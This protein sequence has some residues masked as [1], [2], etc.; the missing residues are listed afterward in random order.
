MLPLARNIK[1]Y[2]SCKEIVI[3]VVAII[4]S[5]SAAVGVYLNLRSD[6]IINDNGKQIVVKTMK[7]TV[8]E[9]LAQNG[10]KV[11]CYDFISV[12]LESKLHK[13]KDNKIEIIRAVPINVF[14]DGKQNTL[15]TARSTVKEALVYSQYKLGADDRI[16]GAS[17]DDKIVK[18]MGVKIVRVKKEV[19]K[20]DVQLPFRVVS[21]E[22]GNMDKG[23]E[24]TLKEGQNGLKQK[25][26]EVVFEDGKQVARNFINEIL[27]ALPA[28][29]IVEIGTL[30]NHKTSRGDTLRY[31]K[32]ID[33][34]STAYTASA[35]D[36]GKG[37]G[38]M[39]FGITCTG[40]RA[41]KGTIAVDPRVIPLHSR[42]YVEVAGDTPDYGFARAE[43]V[44]GAIKGNLI[45]LFFDSQSTANS[46]GRKRVKVYIL[47]D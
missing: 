7:S 6:V 31:T 17:P 30:L 44:G 13:I 28:D 29:K 9:V 4:I 32:V 2:F 21:R 35:A 3:I 39:G 45:D 27:V 10:V 12:P 19:V 1:R 11:G 40:I 8:K 16:E 23:A 26:Y 46:W 34:Y 18:D 33:M 20:E 43:D 15:M 22:N 41:R 25:S 42:V 37:P 24:K 38:D 5:V 36:T 14:A 47:A